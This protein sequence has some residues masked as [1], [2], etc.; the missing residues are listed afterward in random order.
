MIEKC[1]LYKNYLI[2]F[3]GC[4]NGNDGCIVLDIDKNTITRV[5][6]D[7]ILNKRFQHDVCFWKENKFI[8]HGGWSEPHR[9]NSTELTTGGVFQMSSDLLILSIHEKFGI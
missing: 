9:D 5:E 6:I 4:R 1:I 2:N 7:D 3:S 8:I